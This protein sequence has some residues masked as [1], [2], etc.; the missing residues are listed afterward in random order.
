MMLSWQEYLRQGT[1]R[2]TEI[3]ASRIKALV[4][5]SNDRI[6]VISEIKLDAQNASILFTNYYDALR[7][8]CEALA[9]LKGYKIYLH[10]TIGLFLR[11]ILNETVIFTKFDK[12]RILRNGVN[13]YGRAVHFN[14]AVQS[15]EDIKQIISELKV[16]YLKDYI[17]QDKNKY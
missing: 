4:Q 3:N 13:Y 1:V 11:E 12:L 5:M 16:K 15:I 14:E 6:R 9:L 8:V 17:S 7:E 2:K 10:E